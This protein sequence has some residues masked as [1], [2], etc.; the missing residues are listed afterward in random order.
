M[1]ASEP[2]KVV[3]ARRHVSTATSLSSVTVE[4]G[5][6][7]ASVV[8]MLLGG[9]WVLLQ[10]ADVPSPIERMGEAVVV[11]SGLAVMLVL[12][13]FRTRPALIRAPGTW[14]RARLADPDLPRRSRR[15][16]GACTTSCTGPPRVWRR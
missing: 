10:R 16:S 15:S 3:L 5:F 14:W 4:N 6:Y 12:W 13:M 11:V 2:A 8:A 1:L 9:V 7:T